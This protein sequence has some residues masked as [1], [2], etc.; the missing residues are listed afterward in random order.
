LADASLGLVSD[1]VFEGMAEDVAIDE[2]LFDD[3]D[4]LELEEDEDEVAS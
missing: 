4:D 1:A 3:V 2:S